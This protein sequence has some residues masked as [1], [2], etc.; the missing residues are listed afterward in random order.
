[1]QEG[2]VYRFKDEFCKEL[3]IPLNQS[4]RRL[5]EQFTIEALGSEF[6]PN[7]KSKVARDAI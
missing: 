2:K 7:S 4:E 6:K 1:M 5:D 3:G